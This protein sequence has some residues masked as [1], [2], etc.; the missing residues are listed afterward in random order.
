MKETFVM[1]ES[2]V[3][4]PML[5]KDMQTEDFKHSLFRGSCCV[6]KES[7]HQKKKKK[8]NKELK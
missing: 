4:V 2:S 8:S 7:N 3:S 6:S 5:A 1:V